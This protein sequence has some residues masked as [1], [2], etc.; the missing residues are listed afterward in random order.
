ML[1]VFHSLMLQTVIIVVKKINN[2]V[3]DTK[4]EKASG[5]PVSVH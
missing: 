5:L 4:K 1:P 2:L 3:N